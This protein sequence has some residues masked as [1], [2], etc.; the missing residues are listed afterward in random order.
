MHFKLTPVTKNKFH[1]APLSVV[2][3]PEAEANAADDAVAALKAVAECAGPLR[4]MRLSAM[5]SVCSN[6]LAMDHCSQG[7][8]GRNMLHSRLKPP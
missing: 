8:M 4:G 6:P 5:R 3:L 7:K 1:C 2:G